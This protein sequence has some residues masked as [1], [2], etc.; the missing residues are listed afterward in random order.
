MKVWIFS[1]VVHLLLLWALFRVRLAPEQIIEPAVV[2][3]AYSYTQI[4]PKPV[5]LP[6]VKERVVEQTPQQKAV[7]LKQQ[8]REQTEVSKTTVLPESDI[9]T[10]SERAEKPNTE[11]NLPSPA[12]SLSLAERALATASAIASTSSALERPKS[13]VMQGS[14]SQSGSELTPAIIKEIK[15]YADGSLLVEGA[16]GCWKV[17]PTELRKG[18]T[19]L[20]TSTP[21]KEDKTVDQINNILQNRRS[22]YPG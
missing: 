5:P 17:P 14:A 22:Y 10:A 3:S 4:R 2:I 8:S 11:Q 12:S 7:I 15:R 13:Q 18:A 20:V 9:N 19:W 21:C 1:L 6:L 16:H